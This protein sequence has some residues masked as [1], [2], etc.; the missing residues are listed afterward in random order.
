ML[1]AQGCSV[2]VVLQ[3]RAYP[4]EFQLLRGVRRVQMIAPAFSSPTSFACDASP[5]WLRWAAVGLMTTRFPAKTLALH[6]M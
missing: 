1:E 4:Q 3:G 2:P 6:A 5:C